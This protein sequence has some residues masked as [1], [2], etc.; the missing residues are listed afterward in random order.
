MRNPVSVRY[1]G[2]MVKSVPALRKGLRVLEVLAARPTPLSA[3]SVAR[4]LGLARST[5]YDLLG[6]LAA[7]GFAQHLPAQRRWGLGVRA[8]EIG[9]GYLRGQPLEHLG[10]PVV[11]RL[12]D[13]AGPVSGTAHL[14]VLHGNQVLYLVK[15]RCATYGPTLVTDVGVRLPAPLT[16]TGLA[17]LAHL[18]FAQ[19]RALF[20]GPFVT[21]TGRGPTSLAGLRA[22]LR[23]V[24]AR[25]WAIEH[26]RV[27][28]DTASVAVAAFDHAGRPLAA[29]GVTIRHACDGCDEDF[30]ALAASTASAAAALTTAVG[31][32]FP[33]DR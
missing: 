11:H 3:A 8:F 24:S 27:S 17:L 22:D 28:V 31:G 23:A 4:E 25:G 12:A 10:R 16:A 15:D 5:V 13:A 32:K 18:P 6:E 20:D 1:T 21:R 30:A 9:S 2:Q 14:G 29:L 19:V 7:A 26:G 33:A